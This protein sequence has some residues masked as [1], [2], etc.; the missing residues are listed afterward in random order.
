MALNHYVI[1]VNRNRGAIRVLLNKN[2]NFTITYQKSTDTIPK[3][4]LSA[5]LSEDII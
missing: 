3:G 2:Q 4:V 5:H 1:V